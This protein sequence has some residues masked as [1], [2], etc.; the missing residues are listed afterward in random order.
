MSHYPEQFIQIRDA[1]PVWA[2]FRCQPSA[3]YLFR[4]SK[5]NT[6]NVCYSYHPNYLL[7]SPGGLYSNTLY[8]TKKSTY[9][10][11]ILFD[12]RILSPETG[13]YASTLN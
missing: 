9:N 8:R 11:Y 6:P 3:R 7:I 1:N 10:I 12:T 13:T 2:K 5:I 4:Q